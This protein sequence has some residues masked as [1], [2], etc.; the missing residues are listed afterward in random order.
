MATRIGIQKHRP[1]RGNRRG[2]AERGGQGL[3]WL[4]LPAWGHAMLSVRLTSSTQRD[5]V[6]RIIFLNRKVSGLDGPGK[7]A[8]SKQSSR[9]L[10]SHGSSW[11]GTR[12]H[13]VPSVA[14]RSLAGLLPEDHSGF[15]LLESHRIATL[16]RTGMPPSHRSA[17]P[18]R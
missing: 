10:P 14:V 16:T 17:K 8:R 5:R 2:S 6:Y 12:S 9:L 13:A 3:K 18:G 4:M 1:E 15:P 7:K 11:Q